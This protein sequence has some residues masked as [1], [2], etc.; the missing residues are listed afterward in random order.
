MGLDIIEPAAMRY[1]ECK[2]SE[3]IIK[4]CFKYVEDVP[5]FNNDLSFMEPEYLPTPLPIN[6]C[7]FADTEDYV[8]A[9]GFGVAYTLPKFDVMDIDGAYS[10]LKTK[11]TSLYGA[12]EEACSTDTGYIL[13]NGLQEY[14]YT[15]Y[16]IKWEG[17]NNTA[18]V[19]AC[20]IS[21]SSAAHLGSVSCRLTSISTLRKRTA[22]RW[23]KLLAKRW[24]RR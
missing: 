19:M 21:P 6:L 5:Y 1:T 10:D 15:K 12:G 16:Q 4:L 24:K 11:L 7:H 2:L 17:N 20:A 3:K 9:I 23:C 22:M 13:E 18:V 14:E 8:S